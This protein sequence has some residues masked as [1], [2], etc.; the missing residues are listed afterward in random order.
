LSLVKMT[1]VLRSSCCRLDQ[2]GYAVGDGVVEDP[3]GMENSGLGNWTGPFVRGPKGDQF[4]HDELFASDAVLLGR[5]TYDG[6]AAVWPTVKDATGLA[7]RMNALPKFVVSSADAGVTWNNSTVISGDLPS[8]VRALKQ[9]LDRDILIYGSAALVH[10]LMPAGLIDEFRLM[11]Y[12]T[13]LGRGRRLFPDGAKSALTLLE[14][15]Q[16]DSGIVLLR[17][18]GTGSSDT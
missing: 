9:R 3:V 16:F 14:C 4:K 1:S 11:V 10:A 5:R 8:G 7:E 6:F 15:A 12:P 18:Q 13:V 17:Y 2:Y